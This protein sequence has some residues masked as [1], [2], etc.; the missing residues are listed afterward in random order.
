MCTLCTS[1]C[2]CVCAQLLSCW[3]VLM[4]HCTGRSG[5]SETTTSGCG[6]GVASVDIDRQIISMTCLTS[7]RVEGDQERERE[8][9]RRRE[10]ERE[11][12]QLMT[13]EQIAELR[14]AFSLFDKDG[15]GTITTRELGTVMRS[16]GQ[17]PTETELQVRGIKACLSSSPFPLLLLSPSLP[18]SCLPSLPLSLSLPSLPPSL[19]PL[20][21]SFLYFSPSLL[22]TLS[23]PPLLPSFQ[24]QCIFQRHVCIE[25]MRS[26]FPRHRKF[27]GGRGL[28]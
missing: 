6:V 24:A 5:Y 21:S 12:S 17:N 16:L 2:T 1:V 22:P 20:C 7:N 3:S 25:C 15:D 9:E 26:T 27:G 10:R 19:P 18:F 13:E 8:R 28:T 4:P 11:L 23:S 14:E